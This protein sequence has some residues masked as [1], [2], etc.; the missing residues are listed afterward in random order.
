MP[1]YL[2]AQIHRV[3]MN[4]DFSFSWESRGRK[5]RADGTN[6]VVGLESLAGTRA[7]VPEI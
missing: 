6:R 1:I 7:D 5:W 4:A 2:E 3:R